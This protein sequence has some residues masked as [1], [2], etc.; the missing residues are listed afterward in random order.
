MYVGSTESA[1]LFVEPLLT[2]GT[3]WL[4]GEAQA[5]S[6]PSPA[7]SRQRF[8]IGAKVEPDL[9]LFTNGFDPVATRAAVQVSPDALPASLLVG[10]KRIAPMA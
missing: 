1:Q 9:N 4:D 2:R 7:A 8:A 3:G 5:L 6:P 10:A